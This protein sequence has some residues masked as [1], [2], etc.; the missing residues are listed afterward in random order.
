M[1]GMSKKRKFGSPA[2][3]S[4]GNEEK[5]CGASQVIREDGSRK[6]TERQVDSRDTLG[7]GTPSNDT[8][9]HR[10]RAG[11]GVRLS[12][13]TKDKISD[14]RTNEE[15]RDH[16]TRSGRMYNRSETGTERE[17]LTLSDTMRKESDNILRRLDKQ[18][19]MEGIKQTVREGLL[20]LADTVETEMKGIHESIAESVREMVKVELAEMKDMVEGLKER[21][22]V[23][24]DKGTEQ[25]QKVEERIVENEEKLSSL[26]Q[27][28]LG[29]RMENVEDRLKD[30]EKETRQG[31]V[32]E[33]MEKI[34]EKINDTE[35]RL[36]AMRKDKEST[37]V[38]MDKQKELEVRVKE[39]EER[40]ET[41][42]QAGEKA[43]RKESEREMR[44]RIEAAGKN[45]KYFGIDLGPGPKDRR[46]MV[47]RAIT[48]MRERVL[49]K[50]KERFGTVINRTRIR[51]LGKNT[52]EKQYLGRKID[53]LPVL[54]E[55]RT[56]DDK[57]TLEAILR[58]AGW[59]SSFEWPEESMEFI[60]EA[61]KEMNK[62]G[63]VERLHNMRIRP[64]VRDG[65]TK[66]RCEVR[67]KEGGRLR[68][69]AAWEAPPTDRTL[70]NKEQLRPSLTWYVQD[71][72]RS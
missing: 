69:V 21:W 22:T 64:E 30:I 31:N 36:A 7:A 49:Q 1:V 15:R 44:D 27:D 34:E 54:L 46:E 52:E 41:L 58:E 40:M 4:I 6:E 23:N 60:R 28:K 59:L 9:R 51:L 8:D 68:V 3:K 48:Q 38:D 62:L 65:R 72:R 16:V 20:S 57:K 67:D 47:N 45:L 61:K 24:E 32:S 37:V 18:D 2:S 19:S 29:E 26:G 39:N 63:Y 71:R 56:E 14:D 66:I 55:C 12:P 50:D 42:R 53:T 13:S 17:R 33:R 10:R 11:P 70:W 5:E 35:V 43:M 25:M